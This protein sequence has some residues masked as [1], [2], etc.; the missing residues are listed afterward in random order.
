MPEEV[1]ARS[2]EKEGRQVAE[3][4]GNLNLFKT[5]L[6]DSNMQPLRKDGLCY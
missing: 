5:F 3:S 6:S 1:A 4:P 2:L